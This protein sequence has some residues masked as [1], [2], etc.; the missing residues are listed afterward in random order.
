MQYIEF[1]HQKALF[2]WAKHPLVLKEYPELEMLYANRNT[3]RA[4]SKAQAARI[5]AEGSKAGVPD[6]FLPIA[7]CH[8]NG[9]YIE[10]KAPDRKPKTSR[11][12]GGLSPEQIEFFPKL[13]ERGYL[14]EVCYSWEEAKTVLINYI[15]GAYNP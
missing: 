13:E 10:M 1:Q 11:G 5:K 12:K 15:T 4:T 14:V 3:Q 8:Y 9:L 2:Q 7:Q 6:I